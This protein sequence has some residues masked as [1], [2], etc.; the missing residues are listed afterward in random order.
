MRE[1]TERELRTE[2]REKERRK[3]EKDRETGKRIEG[4]TTVAL[5]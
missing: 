2:E 1:S 5:S 3:R 4:A